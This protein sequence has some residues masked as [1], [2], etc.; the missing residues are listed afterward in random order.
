MIAA[1]GNKSFTCSVKECCESQVLIYLFVW[2]PLSGW[3][4]KTRVGLSSPLGL[5]VRW[6]GREVG[7]ATEGP[8]DRYSLLGSAAKGFCALVLRLVCSVESA[9]PYGSLSRRG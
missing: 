7:G 5:P 8:A 9:D 1:L 6:F 4:W 3:G 2:E